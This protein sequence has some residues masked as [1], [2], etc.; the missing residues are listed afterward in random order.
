M[1]V[2]RKLRYLL[3][4]LNCRLGRHV[5]RPVCRFGTLGWGCDYCDT[6]IPPEG[7]DCV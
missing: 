2:L 3:R 4:K 5:F 7:R 6:F 1:K